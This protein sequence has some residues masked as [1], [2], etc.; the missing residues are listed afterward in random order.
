M[1][2]FDAFGDELYSGPTHLGEQFLTLFVDE[3][4][5]AQIYER[6]RSS[7]DAARMLPTGT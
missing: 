3:C 4:D 1:F 5:V 7:G 2:S 6:G